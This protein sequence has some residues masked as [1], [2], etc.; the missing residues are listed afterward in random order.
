[1]PSCTLR[2][3]LLLVALVMF[4]ASQAQSQSIIE[5]K[6]FAVRSGLSGGFDVGLG[7][8]KNYLN[9]SLVYYELTSLTKSNA[10]FVGWTARVS[11]FYGKEL[12]YYTAPAR[13]TQV[14][15]I[16]TVSFGRLSQTSLNVGLRAEWNLGRLQL[17]A[18]V[19]LLGFTFLGRAR[20]GRVYSSTGLFN[21]TDSLDRTIQK[22][23]Q[24]QDAFQ[25]ASPTRV[26]VK[27]LGDHDRGMSTTELYA[28]VFLATNMALKVGYQ[29]V[30]TEMALDNRDQVANN[31]RFRSRVGS[32]YVAL[33]FPLTPW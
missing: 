31:D 20:V 8:N 2:I 23:F 19:D 9:P 14:E 29:W 30:T 33:T 24:G 25:S 15:T 1:M 3:K 22:P 27:L 6:R 21:Q 26:N 28:R 5:Q 11:A 13:L 10:V 7:F 18:S 4:I 17:G 32:A 12:N 16:D